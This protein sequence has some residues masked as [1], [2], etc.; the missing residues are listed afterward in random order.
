MKKGMKMLQRKWRGIYRL[1]FTYQ[2]RKGEDAQ[3]G[4]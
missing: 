3:S 2:K 1:S 4:D